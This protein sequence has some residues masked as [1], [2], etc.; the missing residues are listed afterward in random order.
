MQLTFYEEIERA[1]LLPI[2]GMSADDVFDPIRLFADECNNNMG[3]ALIPGEYITVDESMGGLVWQSNVGS[4]ARS[5]EANSE[6]SRVPH[7]G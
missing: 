1:F 6:W 2:Y 4:H 7:D 5:S 3:K